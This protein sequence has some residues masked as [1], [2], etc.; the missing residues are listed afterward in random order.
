MGFTKDK[1]KLI[2]ETGDLAYGLN[3]S[4]SKYFNGVFKYV[5]EYGI[6]FPPKIVDSFLTP[7]EIAW[8]ESLEKLK[9]ANYRQTVMEYNKRIKYT[10]NPEFQSYNE[11]INKCFSEHDK[12]HTVAETH[13]F[14]DTEM[15]TLKSIKKMKDKEKKK[16]MRYDDARQNKSRNINKYTELYNKAERKEEGINNL[17]IAYIRDKYKNTY[18]RDIGRKCKGILEFACREENDFI[19]YIHFLLDELDMDQVTKK[20]PVKD[21]GD[22]SITGQE[23]RWIYRNRENGNVANK[24]QFWLDEKPIVPP[25]EIEKWKSLWE[26]YGNS[27]KDK[28]AKPIKPTKPIKSTKSVLSCFKWRK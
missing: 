18:F 28:P 19:T 24:I 10:K 25:W 17:L 1:F 3:S 14:T 26:D 2:F 7:A 22:P 15:K 6:T 12:Y 5:K 20:I 8:D 13:V 16:M 4:R 23:L 27:R 21:S 9:V 11:R